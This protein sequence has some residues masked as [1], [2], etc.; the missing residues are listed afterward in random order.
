[1]K[2]VRENI[3]RFVIQSND[4]DIS[5]FDP[6]FLDN[7]I[8]KRMSKTQCLS[9]LTYI[10]MLECDKRESIQLI[11]SLR[12][13]YSEFFRNSITWS[14]L[15]CL[16]LPEIIL[17]KQSPKKNEL[18]I[19]SAA[20]A[21]GQESYSIAM[22]LKGMKPVQD[23]HIKFRIFATDRDEL[24]INESRKGI[25]TD[26]DIGN[27][28]LKNINKWFSHKEETYSIVPELKENITFSIF[29]LLD[30]N[31]SCPPISIFGG[32]DIVF[33]SNILF[34]Y[35]TEIQEKILVKVSNSLSKGGYLVTGEA[36]RGILIKHNFKE[37][38]PQSAIFNISNK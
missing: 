15:D 6:K 23:N 2:E 9:P 12:I 16:I 31:F 28:N 3:I 26:R 24:L 5:R 33:C 4:I 11:D 34:Y 29:D 7:S 30:E 32:F 19:W 13:S 14:V 37:A 20:C 18:R 27:V 10:K 38:F 17:Q 35:S 1:M 36:E 8:R 21:K 22:M 25:Y